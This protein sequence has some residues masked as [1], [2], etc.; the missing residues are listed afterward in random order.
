MDLPFARKLIR[1]TI[2]RADSVLERSAHAAMR[3]S[4]GSLVTDTDT[5]MQAELGRLLVSLAP[6]SS[7]L[8]EEMHRGEQEAA[9]GDGNPCWV[10][11]PIDGTS[12]FAT[13]L[14][15]YCISL[16]RIEDGETRF[17]MVYD[18]CRKECFWALRGHGAW[19]NDEP[20]ARPP[21]PTLERSI[22]LVDTKRLSRN[23]GLALLEDSPLH[24]MRNLGAVALEWCWV[25]A[26][27]GHVYLHGKQQLWDYAAAQL[28]LREAGGAAVDLGG[29]D[30][31][32]LRLE[33][34]GM[35]AAM[36]PHL[37]AEWRDWIDQHFYGSRS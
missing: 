8:G 11:D 21:S 4:D 19:L 14:P 29:D 37:L 35:I 34:R 20:L 28:I 24:S 10:L 9:L 22:G 16:A 25:A 13:D 15:F 3:K 30:P 2:A 12:N 5:R 33:P 7:L 36:S 17:G 18:P 32:P 27:R 31:E 23:I 26:G 6:G 1:L